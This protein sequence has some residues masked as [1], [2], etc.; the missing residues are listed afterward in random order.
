MSESNFESMPDSMIAGMLMH[1]SSEVHHSHRALVDEARRR[2]ALNHESRWIPVEERL[3]G[4]AKCALVLDVGLIMHIAFIADM[5]WYGVGDGVQIQ[6]DSRYENSV[7]VRAD[8]V[9]ERDIPEKAT[10]GRFEDANYI[11]SLFQ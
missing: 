9:R 1:I 5:K 2:L 4:N 8:L 10:R 7:I 6:A 11:V 3:P